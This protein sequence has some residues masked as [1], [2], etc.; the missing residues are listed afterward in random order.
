MRSLIATGA[1]LVLLGCPL[2][3]NVLYRCEQDGT[4]TTAG[5]R[6]APDGYCHP[7]RDFVDAGLCVPGDVAASCAAVD[8]GF[9]TDGCGVERLCERTCPASQEC[10]VNAPNRCGFPALCTAEGWCWEHPLP[11]GF[12]LNAALRLDARHTWLVGENRT[13]LFFDGARSRL[14]DAPAPPGIDLHAIHGTAPNDVFVVGG[15]GV[16][17]HFDGTRWERE[18]TLTGFNTQ[19]RTVWSLGDGGAI[20]A[21]PGGH[22]LSRAALIDPFSRWTLEMF[23]SV[24]EIRDV[25]ADADGALYAVTRRNELFTRDPARVSDWRRLDTVPLTETF[26]GLAHA[27]GLTFGGNAVDR[28]TVV[29]R[30]ADGGWRALTDAGFAAL[31]LIPADG[32]IFVLGNSGS[33]FAFLDDAENFTR[34]VVQPGAWSAAT[35]LPG[36]KLLVAGVAGATAVVELDG[37]L[38]W[39]STPRVSRGQSLNALCGASPEAMFAVGGIDNGAACPTCKV[40]WLER[41]VGSSGVHWLAKD[42]QLGNTTQLL[43]CYAESADRVWM[44]GNDSKFVFLSAAQATWGDFG[45]GGLYGQY[46]GAWGNPDAGYI[47]TRR[48]SSQ[49]TTSG[50]GLMGF[51]VNDIG[52]GGGLRSVWGLGPDDIMVAGLN[53]T[54]SRYDGTIWAQ[55]YVGVS[56]ELVSVHGALTLDGGRRYVAAGNAGALYSVVGD[57]GVLGQLS[58]A[59]NFASTWVS[60]RGTAWA[61]GKAS[62]GG[63]FVVR[64][65]PGGAWALEPLTSP[66]P[67]TGVFGFDQAD[68]GATVWL[69]GQQGMI[70]R[71][72]E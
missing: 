19:L 41:Q 71:K 28:G 24:D 65:E 29:H 26:A 67:V 33:D 5:L 34:F 1:F 53:G 48:E 9:V 23:P 2:P 15:G 20:A 12:N 50:D 69:S 60:A 47:F 38:S 4:C 62:D 55:Q 6:C 49:L 64:S 10:G 30:G 43:A 46:S 17:L 11:Q 66:R 22:L 45:G 13:V 8:C 56:N 68:G 14:Q 44:P 7:E 42:F 57:A 59:V 16:M 21:G 25:F 18:G 70:L 52:G 35:A 3:S 61:V 58:P 72:Q 51:A 40:R 32:G 54:T 36:P 31:E 39:R 27:G 37:G 63:A